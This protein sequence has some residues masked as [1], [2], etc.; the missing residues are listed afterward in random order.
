MS[1]STW[2]R[3]SHGL[4]DYE[5]SDTWRQSMLVS[6]TCYLLRIGN[7]VTAI[8]DLTTVEA[9]WSAQMLARVT[10]THRGFFVSPCE[11][12]GGEPLWLIMK[13]LEQN[14]SGYPLNSGTV[15]KLG[16][17]KLVMR[18]LN[19]E[20]TVLSTE[21]SSDEEED[22][23]GTCRI[24]FSGAYPDDPLITPCLC[25][26]SLRHIHFNCLKYWLDTKRNVAQNETSVAYYWESLLCEIC[27]HPLP[28]SITVKG[29]K[30]DLFKLEEQSQTTIALEMLKKDT[31]SRGVH[32]I[33]MKPNSSVCLGRGHESDVRI[34]DISVS[35][36][37]ALLN[38]D[39]KQFY[40]KDNSSKFGSLIQVVNP[41]HVGLDQKLV[42]QI[43]RTVIAFNTTMS[44]P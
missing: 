44:R 21:N 14:A 35:R 38:Y 23:S 16:R 41:V 25:S 42:L 5:S 6:S 18:E 26:G 34:S 40:L 8:E 20:E 15:L 9:S 2:T 31:R 37:H 22:E 17:V 33:S 1:A 27:K 32:L 12:I 36:L 11:D 19:S 30:Y 13:E 28:L 3:D 24:C 29:K 7:E 39:G 4:Y 10:K 43:G